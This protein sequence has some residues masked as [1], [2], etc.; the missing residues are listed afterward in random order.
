MARASMSNLD[1]NVWVRGSKGIIGS[2]VDNVYALG[3]SLYLKFRAGGVVRYVVLE[4]GVR[5]HFTN[6][7]SGLEEASR[8]FPLVVKKHVRDA[9]LLDV[10]Q[11]GFDR[12]LRFSFQDGVELYVELLPRGFL[13]LA[14]DG[15]V[16]AA[17][18][19]AELRDRV[20]RPGVE[21]KP[22]P[23]QTLN[24]FTIGLEELASRVT[25]GVDI[26][27]GLIKG[28]G[29]PGEVAEEAVYRA[30]LNPN[31]NP[32]GLTI[33]DYE[34]LLGELKGLYEESLAGRGF[35]ILR[36]SV[37]V[38]ATPFKPRRFVDGV[39]VEL[40][41][42]D[43]ALD[44]L[45]SARALTVEDPLRDERVKLERS[46]AEARELEATYRA[47]AEARRRE[48][49]AL[50]ANYDLLERV[51]ECARSMWRLR[52]LS[53]CKY[54]EE[55][56]F[57]KGFYYVNLGGL[58]VKI[59]YGESVQ[60]AIVRLYREAGELEAKA[61]RA[62]KAVEEAL[63]RLAELELKAKARSIALRAKARRVAWFERF[64][65]TITSNGFLAI[66]G[67][68]ASQNESLVRRYLEDRDVFLHADIQGG[69]AVVLKTGG[70]EPQVE[71]LE[72]AAVLA[73]CYSKAW[74][75]GFGSVDVYWVYGSQVSKSA[76][77]GEYLRT[78]AF[79][80][81]GERNYIRNVKLQLALGVTLDNEGNPL[82][83]VGSE[84]VV[85]RVS[86][87]YVILAPGDRGLDEA[88]HVKEELV[89]VVDEESKPLVMAVEVDHI[90]NM[91]PGR[92]RILKVSRGEQST[93][94]AYL[95]LYYGDILRGV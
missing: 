10:E 31:S 87:A 49:E 84:R 80:V 27:R 93:S 63:A 32:R 33:G 4:A 7:V 60:D 56:D 68:D 2:R 82:V 37:P 59:H 66:G 70:S 78:G 38:E 25:V 5:A 57:N 86:I 26:V 90:E 74:K 54:V 22:P 24:P 19:Y 17:S 64:R 44:E 18:R 50:A 47:E 15:R 92:F 28:L 23:L 8:G 81:Y 75:A 77:A 45:F 76:P 11:L 71:D 67:R 79:M 29:L 85:R 42:F 61:R 6:R 41:S 73:A 20:V 9:K 3:E 1:V 62:G 40:S 12:V 69:S 13:V 88:I 21:Y 72:D 14:R 36:G 65:W 34:R 30:G 95:P 51:V 83:F 58:K 43:E 52:D 94:T 89:R 16:T 91:I 53:S 35:L 55:V 46:L 39:V 48:A